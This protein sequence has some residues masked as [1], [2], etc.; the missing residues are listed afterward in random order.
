M[1]ITLYSR[2]TAQVKRT[3]R[4]SLCKSLCETWGIKHAILREKVVHSELQPPSGTLVNN[5]QELR[6]RFFKAMEGPKFCSNDGT[7]PS[8]A[9]VR[10]SLVKQAFLRSNFCLRLEDFYMPL[11]PKNETWEVSSICVRGR[12]FRRARR[13]SEA[14]FVLWFWVLL[15]MNGCQSTYHNSWKNR[16]GFEQGNQRVG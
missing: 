4:L 15:H 14:Q 6:K 12:E 7:V 9:S 10:V 2:Q 13:Q 8:I 11:L 16:D 5:E 1:K 3:H